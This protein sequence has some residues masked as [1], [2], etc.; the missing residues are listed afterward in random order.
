VGVAEQLMLLTTTFPIGKSL[1]TNWESAQGTQPVHRSIDMKLYAYPGSP[2]CSKVL[3]AAG[4][5]EIDIEIENVSLERLKTPEYRAIHPLGM[6]PALQDG[7]LTLWESGAILAH[8]AGKK[9]KAGL[10]PDEPAARAD[11]LRWLLFYSAHVHPAVYLL[12]WE[13][14]IK[15]LITGVAGADLNRVAYA[16]EQLGRVLPIL[17]NQLGRGEWLAGRY[18][19]VDIAV[20]VSLIALRDYMQFD[21]GPY[22]AILSWLGRMERRPA[23]R[24]VLRQRD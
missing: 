20:G 1:L 14:G 18:G 6:V 10:L 7:P 24:A 3:I 13:R 16:E 23:W 11:T 4:E 19:I 5:L 15:Q 17:S 9:P 2:N 21:L 12:G 22:P 8:L